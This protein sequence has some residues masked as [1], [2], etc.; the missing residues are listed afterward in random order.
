MSGTM[1]DGKPEQPATLQVSESGE[2]KL[3]MPP[4]PPNKDSPTDQDRD[5][6]NM[7]EYIK[8]SKEEIQGVHGCDILV[9][10][11]F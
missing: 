7:N 11:P 2:V 3:E 8:V 5:P 1:S 10:F 6:N 4:T 9:L